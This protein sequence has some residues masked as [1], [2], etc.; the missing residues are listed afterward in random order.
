MNLRPPRSPEAGRALICITTGGI[1]AVLP[2]GTSCTVAAPAGILAGICTEI[3]PPPPIW[4]VVGIK[5]TWSVHPATF[6]GTDGTV[7]M[8]A[9]PC[10]RSAFHHGC[11]IQNRGPHGHLVGIGRQHLQQAVPGDLLQAADSREI[12]WTRLSIRADG[13]VQLHLLSRSAPIL[14]PPRRRSTR[15]PPETGAARNKVFTPM[16]STKASV[17]GNS[18]PELRTMEGFCGPE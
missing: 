9:V 4:N 11:L 10:G 3:R 7:G 8:M 16:M 17:P 1:V 13:Y 15:R 5:S 2:G 12:H 18:G 14:G 6:C